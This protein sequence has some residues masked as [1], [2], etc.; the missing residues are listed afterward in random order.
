MYYSL[1]YEMR[2]IYILYVLY[3]LNTVQVSKMLTLWDFRE[4]LRWAVGAGEL[5]LSLNSG[6]NCLQ[7]INCHFPF[8]SHPT[9]P[10]TIVKIKGF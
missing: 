2:I 5:H 10:Q 7:C 8:L 1:L 9:I 3:T 6:Q 4:E